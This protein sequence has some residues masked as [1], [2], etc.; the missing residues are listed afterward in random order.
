[1]VSTIRPALLSD[2]P[3]VAALGE[4]FHAE[5]GWP[6]IAAPYVVEDCAQSLRLMVENPA[7]ILLVAEAGGHLVGM[8]G[9]LAHP[10]YFNFGHLHGG[11]LFWW[12]EPGLRDGTGAALF[13]ALE[14]AARSIGC[15]TF[16]MS[17]VERLKP[18]LMGRLYTRRGYVPS[19]RSFI[20]RLI[21]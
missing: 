5:A 9:G 3:D 1:M 6:E 12:V 19:E 2:I 10:F 4:R 8:A 20:K 21:P 18:E 14:D 11:E 13:D 15:L 17:A 7:G 16:S